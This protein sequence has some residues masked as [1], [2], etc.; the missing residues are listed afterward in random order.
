MY[1]ECDYN[2]L[3]FK[4]AI[5][6]IYGNNLEYSSFAKSCYEQHQ[7][8]FLSYCGKVYGIARTSE[9]TI[10]LSSVLKDINLGGL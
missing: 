10:K 6:L 8:I 2:I 5:K 3:P 4:E 7:Y 9:K 1:Y